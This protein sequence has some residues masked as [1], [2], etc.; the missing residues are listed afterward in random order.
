MA[1]RNLSVPAP[2]EDEAPPVAEA[3]G[4][5]KLQ[6]PRFSMQLTAEDDEAQ[7]SIDLAKMHPNS[8]A[9]LARLLK[10]GET[11]KEL[12]VID[13][14]PA[15]GPGDSVLDTMLAG[16]AVELVGLLAVI[17]AQRA[18]GL[19][20]EAAALMAFR[21]EQRDNL[22]PLVVRILA[23]YNLLG[24]K[25]AEELAAL[26]L[27]AAMLSDNYQQA[28]KKQAEIDALKQAA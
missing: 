5:A 21:P 2:G 17:G 23:K 15:Q 19:S 20:N 27:V 1:K 12:G 6:A 9:R 8:K 26:A 10:K 4:S 28:S 11:L 25:Y 3:R 13:E 14:R 7:Q 22:A 16:K 24:G 18:G